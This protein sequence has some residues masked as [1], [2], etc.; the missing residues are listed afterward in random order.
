M[1]YCVVKDTA[2][3]IDGSEN[4]TEIM[5]QNALNAGIADFEILTEEEYLARKAL[6]AEQP[7]KKTQL[8]ILQETVDMLV[9]D[10]LE[11]I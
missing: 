1:R 10:N 6:E 7:R 8:E 11:G 9:L 5:E 4:P 2:I 3:V